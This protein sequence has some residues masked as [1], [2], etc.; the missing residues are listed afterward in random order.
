MSTRLT[1]EEVV[2]L[3][4]SSMTQ[5]FDRGA[6]HEA[7]SQLAEERLGEIN[8]LR[9]DIKEANEGRM[10]L[11]KRWGARE[12]ETMGQFI[13][14]GAINTQRLALLLELLDSKRDCLSYEDIMSEYVSG[15]H[16]IGSD[17]EVVAESLPYG[18]AT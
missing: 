9:A 15:C 8:Q 1:P 12:D 7:C 10:A 17:G 3:F 13:A 16:A 11:R 6:Y 2:E 4:Q 5:T 18:V 14:R